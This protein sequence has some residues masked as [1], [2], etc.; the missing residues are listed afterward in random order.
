MDANLS[1]RGEGDSKINEKKI[2][3][4]RQIAASVRRVFSSRFFG[5]RDASKGELTNLKAIREQRNVIFRREFFFVARFEESSERG[6]Y[7]NIKG[8]ENDFLIDIRIKETRFENRI[9]TK[10]T[11][12]NFPFDPLSLGNSV[13]RR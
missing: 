4:G 5:V 6:F 1:R 12:L 13:V 2:R 8:S 9:W 3:I 10:S 11:R 7:L